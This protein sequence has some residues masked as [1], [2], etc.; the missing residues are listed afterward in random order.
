MGIVK[1]PA[2]PVFGRL[3]RIKEESTRSDEFHPVR[4]LVALVHKIIVDGLVA[5][6]LDLLLIRRITNHRVELLSH[7]KC[8]AFHRSELVWLVFLPVIYD[9]KGHRLC[10]CLIPCFFS[11][12]LEERVIQKVEDRGLH[13]LL[14]AEKRRLYDDIH[15]IGRDGTRKPVHLPEVPRHNPGGLV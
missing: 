2:I 3:T 14:V 1:H 13:G 9:A 6:A 7:V 15:L 12:L 4:D 11:R 10:M 5:R 8:L